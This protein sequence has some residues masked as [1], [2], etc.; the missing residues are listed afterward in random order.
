MDAECFGVIPLIELKDMQNKA[1]FGYVYLVNYKEKSG[2]D[3][4]KNHSYLY[5]GGSGEGT[6]GVFLFL[7]FFK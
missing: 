5:V 2:S 6:L 7:F 1:I 3:K 4:Y